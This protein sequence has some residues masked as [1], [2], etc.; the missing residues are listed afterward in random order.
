LELENF[1]K[2]LS[3]NITQYLVTPEDATAVTKIAEAALISSNTGT[4]VYLS[5]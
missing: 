3:G 1:V 2:S 4:P 5:F